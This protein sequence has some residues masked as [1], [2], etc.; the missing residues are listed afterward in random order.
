M[1][2]AKALAKQIMR[3]DSPW[4]NLPN[5]R[6]IQLGFITLQLGHLVITLMQWQMP[7]HLH[8]PQGHKP[9]IQHSWTEQQALVPLFPA[10][11]L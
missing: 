11:L 9:C 1:H 5:P 6:Q 2:L 10:N 8:Q 7:G 3:L 4:T